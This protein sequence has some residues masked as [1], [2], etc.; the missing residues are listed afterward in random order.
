MWKV[1]RDYLFWVDQF[2]ELAGSC[3]IFRFIDNRTIVY[4]D[5]GTRRSKEAWDDFKSQFPSS[6]TGKVNECITM[7][8]ADLMVLKMT[9][10]G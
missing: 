9:Y 6:S 5:D 2:S 8:D 10:W 1:H 3:L 4:A 7:S